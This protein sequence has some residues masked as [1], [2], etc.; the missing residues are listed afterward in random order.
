MTYDSAE[1]LSERYGPSYRWL[2]TI[3]GMV[4]VVS[5]VLAMTTV[6]VA[7]PDVMG[8]F[9][10]GQDKAQW[11]SSAY[12]ATMTAGMLMNA[13]ITG[14][15]GERRTFVGALFFFSIGALLGGMASTEDTLIFA[16]ILQGFSAGV[17]QPLVMA[18]IFTVFPVERRGMAMGVFGLG[19]VFAPAIGPTLGGLMI[20]YFSWHYV[21]YISL[22]FC[23]IAAVLGLL[24]M[25]TR[26]MP[27]V[28]PPFDWLGFALLCIALLGLMTGI[29]DGQ[30]EGWS[31]DAIVFRLCLGF[32]ATIAFIF[33]ELHTPRAMID[34]RIFASLEFSATAM[35]AFIFGA[36]MMG[37]TYV[38][39]VF[40]QTIIG[41]TPLLAGL[42]MMPAG[43]MLAFIFPLAGRMADAVP[44][45]TMIIAGLLLFAA[46]FALMCMADVDT[47][48]WT[49]VGM[50]MVSRLGLGLINPSL[51]AS[52]LKAVPADKVRQGAGIANF[53][54]QLG[55]AFGINLMVAFF[56]V[57]THFHAEALTATQDWRNPTSQRLLALVEQLLQRDSGLPL[58]QQKAAAYEYLGSMLHAK[59]Q[60]FAFSDTFIVIG[61]VALLALLPAAMLSRSQ[62][63]SRGF[64]LLGKAAR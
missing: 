24:F 12:T 11:M 1:A 26:P 37:S 52:S 5:M 29:A 43:L 39:P 4:G 45:S 25:P 30:R 20:E 62:R 9:G 16:R 63:R 64:S 19:V 3:T 22:P 47:T 8:A 48:F 56:E 33:W 41:F 44:A 17:A 2:V 27:K 61:I 23:V 13:W 21:F 32:G 34:I 36:G 59:A 40:V 28:I 46:G 7:V 55:G 6:N 10:I 38:M 51:N 58:Q 54:R 60:M 53:M 57:R 15:L 50:V 42:M 18:I 35:I 49:L 14:V 31:S